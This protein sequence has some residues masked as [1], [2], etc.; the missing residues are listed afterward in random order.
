MKKSSASFIFETF[1]RSGFRKW[2]AWESRT[3]DV[4]SRN[5]VPTISDVTL[6]GFRALSEIFSVNSTKLLINFTSENAFMPK[7]FERFVKAA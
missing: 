3:Q 4:M 7:R 6:D 1:L 2:L 5:T